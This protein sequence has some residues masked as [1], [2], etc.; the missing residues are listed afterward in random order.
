[1]NAE[2]MNEFPPA[3]PLSAITFSAAIAM[4]LGFGN[5]SPEK[6]RKYSI[7]RSISR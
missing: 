6:S 3:V 2:F 7:R 5:K 4:S 1:M